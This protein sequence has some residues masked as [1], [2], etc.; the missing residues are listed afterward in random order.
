MFV[1][2]VLCM[3]ACVGIPIKSSMDD[4]TSVVYAGLVHQLINTSK[5]V[6][7]TYDSTDDLKFLRLRT[8]KHEICIIPGEFLCNIILNITVY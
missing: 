1:P 6:I 2:V 4:S 7:K 3:I 8:K 5:S